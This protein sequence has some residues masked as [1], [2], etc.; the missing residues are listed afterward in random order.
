MSDKGTS[1]TQAE[2]DRVIRSWL[3]G[4]SL[5]R[6]FTFTGDEVMTYMPARG[7]RSLGRHSQAA[8]GSSCLVAK[9]VCNSW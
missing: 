1:I 6:N 8:L 5:D 7:P 9:R 3:S 4:K 2:G